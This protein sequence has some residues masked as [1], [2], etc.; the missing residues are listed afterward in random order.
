MTSNVMADPHAGEAQWV[1]E[2]ATRVLP[3]SFDVPAWYAKQPIP[4][5]QNRSAADL[6]HSGQARA[7]VAYLESLLEARMHSDAS[8]G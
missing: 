2:V 3:Q 5:L 4:A 7:L 1:I 8:K 6:V